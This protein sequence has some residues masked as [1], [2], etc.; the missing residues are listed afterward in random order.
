MKKIIAIL[1]SVLFLVSFAGCG[2]KDDETSTD[3]GKRVLRVTYLKAGYGDEVFNKLANAFMVKYPDVQVKLYPDENVDSNTETQLTSGKNVKDVYYVSNWSSIRRWAIKGYVEDLTEVYS[4]EVENG[5]SILDVIDDHVKD[6]CKYDERFWALPNESSISGLIYN[7]DMFNQ[8]GWSVPT[9]TK[10]LIDLC[11]TIANA[12][13]SWVDEAGTTTSTK[14]TP[15]VF[16]GSGNDGYWNPTLNVWWLQASGKEQLD[17]FSQFENPDVYVDEGRLK[18]LTVYREVVFDHIATFAPKNVMS[19]DHKAA[20]LDFLRGKAA[21]IP[22]GS[23][24]ATEMRAAIEQFAPNMNFKMMAAP[25]ISD[26][27]GNSLAHDDGVN[28]LWDG[29][30]AC[31]FVPDGK[32]NSSARN[33]EDAKK[34]I[35]FMCSNQALNIWT[36]ET[37][38]IRPFDYDTTSTSELYQNASVFS[39]SLMD[40]WNSVTPYRYMSSDKKAIMGYATL[41][42]QQRSPFVDMYNNQTTAQKYYENDYAFV[43]REWDRW[44]SLTTE[45]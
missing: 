21:M 16:C 1:L 11:Y 3:D 39:K 14:I 8:Y 12:N 31:W 29:G 40:L 6:Y 18:A 10:E 20:Q 25:I 38:G 33:V 19:K 45:G 24:F 2:K 13:I 5:N 23:W 34:W 27:M 42:P 7:E 17:V 35:S 28:Y 4:A 15:L 9:T 37:G 41:W 43:L 22:C 44:V 36:S 26:N 30:G 32:L